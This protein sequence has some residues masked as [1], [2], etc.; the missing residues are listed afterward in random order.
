RTELVYGYDPL[1]AWCYAFGAALHQ[2]RQALGDRLLVR[3]ACVGM[4]RGEAARPVRLAASQLRAGI[5]SVQARTGVLFGERFVHGLLRSETW[6][7]DS[8]PA[9]RA[10]IAAQQL[11]PDRALD[12]ATGLATAFHGCGLEPDAPSTLRAVAM[13]AGIDG[14]ALIERWSDPFALRT[15][16]AHFDHTR[17]CGI[18]TAPSLHL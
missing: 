10:L 16:E 15:T 12:F 1:S 8:E 4:A 9:S 7:F 6:V 13:E 11:A 3:V 2:L 5:R 17:A 18:T 14:D